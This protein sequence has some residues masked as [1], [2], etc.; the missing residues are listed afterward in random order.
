MSEEE[1]AKLLEMK[2]DLKKEFLCWGVAQVVEHLPS[3]CLTRVQSPVQPLPPPKAPLFSKFQFISLQR[4]LLE[5]SADLLCITC[6]QGHL[7]C[8]GEP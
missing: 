1:K 2:P 3:T 8:T 5:A 4:S 7:Y 6:S